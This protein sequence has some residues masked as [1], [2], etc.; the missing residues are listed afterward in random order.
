MTTTKPHHNYSPTLSSALDSELFEEAA[1]RLAQRYRDDTSHKFTYGC[2]AFLFHQGE[3]LGVEDQP[4]HR[5]Y[6]SPRSSPLPTKQ[7]SQ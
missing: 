1:S 3:F 5:R 7:G 2:F 4:K 6:V